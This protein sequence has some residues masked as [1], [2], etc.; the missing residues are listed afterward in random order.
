[1]T[2]K[3]LVNHPAHYTSGDIECI[4][5]IRAQLGDDGYISY[6]QGNVVKY[7][8]RWKRK[9]G[10]QDLKKAQ[11]YL[12]WM[13]EEVE[14]SE[15]VAKDEQEEQFSSAK[16]TAAKQIVER[17]D[18]FAQ[19]FDPYHYADTVDSDHFEST[20]DGFLANEHIDDCVKW[21]ESF[22]RGGAKE[23]Q[24]LIRAIELYQQ[25]FFV[26]NEEVA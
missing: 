18:E 15:K 4:D 26:E 11:T 13:V 5:A 16:F 22:D 2:N 14:L 21:L 7:L 1:M 25:V 10:L 23:A 3:D 9:G 12:S 17:L 8:W 19:D 24:L 6:C 20:L